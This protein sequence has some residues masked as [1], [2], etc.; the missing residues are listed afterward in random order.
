[1]TELLNPGIPS[2]QTRASGTPEGFFYLP[3]FLSQEQH[4]G[5]LLLLQGLTFKRDIVRGKPMRRAYA[6]F[7]YAYVTAGKKVAEA[8]PW[9]EFLAV[10]AAKGLPFC[11]Q[12][13]TFNQCIVT[14]YPAGAGID[15]HPDARVFGDCIMAVSLASAA[16]LQFR[17]NH[18]AEPSYEVLAV[19][20]SLYI[21]QGVA[22]RE[23]QHRVVP[24]KAERFSITFRVVK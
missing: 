9:P 16:R 6:Q 22:R 24:V 8:P 11:P 18:A 15:W 20:G 14:R 21:M 17:P 3:D 5:L 23:Y 4:D 7:G 19:P 2:P 12:G 10:L 1:M 13:T